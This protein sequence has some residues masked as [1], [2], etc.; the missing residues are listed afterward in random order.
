VCAHARPTRLSLPADLGR[1]RLL[2]LP[3]ALEPRNLLAPPAQVGAEL[4]AARVRARNVRG[5]ALQL[6]LLRLEARIGLGRCQALLSA[7]NKCG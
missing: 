2:P 5:Q 3:V 1:T 7:R 4:G 6:L